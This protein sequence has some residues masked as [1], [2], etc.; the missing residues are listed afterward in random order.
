[1]KRRAGTDR[2][3]AI[4]L[5]AGLSK[6]QLAAVDGLVTA[7]DVKSGRELIR[8]GEIGREFFL[9]VSGEAEV[10]RDGAVV[11][12]RGPGAFFGETALLFDEPRNASVVATT[13][14]TV[15]VIHQREFRRLL[16]DHPELE[17]TLLEVAARRPTALDDP[18]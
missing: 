2:L 12:Q 5:F 4:P 17:A 9:V 3:A 15:E 6:K 14:M 8:Q 7:L 11:A 18:A 16:G 13:D 1:M 10:R